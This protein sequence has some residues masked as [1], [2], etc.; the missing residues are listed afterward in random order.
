MEVYKE[1][2]QTTKLMLITPGEGGDARKKKTIM[3]GSRQWVSFY[4]RLIL[5]GIMQGSRD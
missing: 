1:L 4:H 2:R 5:P 3:A